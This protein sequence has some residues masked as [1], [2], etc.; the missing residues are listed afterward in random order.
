M[1]AHALI[2]AELRSCLNRG[3]SLP[4]RPEPKDLWDALGGDGCAALIVMLE[5]ELAEREIR[6]ERAERISYPVAA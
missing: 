2:V 4:I 1:D 3:L 6:Q 5:Y